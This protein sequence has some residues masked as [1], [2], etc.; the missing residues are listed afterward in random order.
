MSCSA[1]RGEANSRRRRLRSLMPLPAAAARV[2]VQDDDA[3]VLA[4]GLG[5]DA[6]DIVA[7]DRGIAVDRRS[8][9]P[10]QL[11]LVVTMRWLVAAPV[12]TR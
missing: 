2:T 7:G 5:G 12:E 1:R 6:Q 10:G 11:D 8:P 4:G 3:V 9:S